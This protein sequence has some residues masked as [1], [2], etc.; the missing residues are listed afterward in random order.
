MMAESMG[1]LKEKV[2]RWKEFVWGKVV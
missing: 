1:E 2:L